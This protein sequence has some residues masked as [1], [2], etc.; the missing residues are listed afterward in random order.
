MVS[1]SLRRAGVAAALVLSVACSPKYYVPNT[2]NV[3]LIG[4]Q[5][6][7]HLTVAGNAN[8]VEVQGAYGLGDALA[9]QVN[10]G[11]VRPGDEDNGNGGS[12][13][14][15]E[16][17]LGYFLNISPT[18]LFDVYALA[19][20]GTVENHFPGSVSANPGTTGEISANLWRFGIQPSISYHTNNWSISGSARVSRLSFSDITG[21]LIFDNAD[22]VDYL[23]TNNSH[24]LFEPALTLRA[25]TGRLQL[26]VQAAKSINITDSNFRQ[27]DRLATVALVLRVR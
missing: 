10:G 24:T 11:L 12:G 14:L 1:V 23:T 21:S 4:A 3:P 6:E 7:G 18:V 19:G 13:K 22:Q 9:I 20:A 26:Q 17:G 27:D 15:I 16:G 25:G 2:Q 8:Q 5:G